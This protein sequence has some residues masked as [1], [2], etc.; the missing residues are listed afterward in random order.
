MDFQPEGYAFH[1]FTSSFAL[2]QHCCDQVIVLSDVF[3]T[4]QSALPVFSVFLFVLCLFFVCLVGF[5]QLW[6]FSNALQRPTVMPGNVFLR[7]LFYRD[8]GLFCCLNAVFI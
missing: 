7:C 2:I 1:R 5:C 4:R 6:R 3:K 8:V